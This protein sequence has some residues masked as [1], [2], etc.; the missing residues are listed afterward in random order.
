MTARL[1]NVF[2][3]AASRPTLFFG[4]VAK[5]LRATYWGFE[6]GSKQQR[7]GLIDDGI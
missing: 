7:E 4:F 3:L 1:R 5:L 2:R 6:I